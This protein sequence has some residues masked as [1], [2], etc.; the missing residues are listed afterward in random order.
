MHLETHQLRCGY[1]P[2]MSGP[3]G[4]NQVGREIGVEGMFQR[5]YESVQCPKEVKQGQD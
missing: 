3:G 1:R 4:R 5:E 2:R